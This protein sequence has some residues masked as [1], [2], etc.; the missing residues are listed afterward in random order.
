MDASQQLRER[1]KKLQKESKKLRIEANEND[2]KIRKI[3]ENLSKICK[4]FDT[5]TRTNS[6]EEPGKVKYFEWQEK[7]CRSC[8]KVVATLEEKTTRKWVKK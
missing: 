4:H 5:Y 3:K 2:F 1:I 8:G 6:Y 7:V